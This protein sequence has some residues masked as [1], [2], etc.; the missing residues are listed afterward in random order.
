MLAFLEQI[1][2]RRRQVAGAANTLADIDRH[3]AYV[4]T[5]ETS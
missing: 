5:T 3:G 1:T 4:F 2:H